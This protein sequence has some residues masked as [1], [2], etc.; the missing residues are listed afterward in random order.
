MPPSFWMSSVASSCTTSTMSSAVTM[1]RM[2]PSASTTGTAP[3]SSS[4]RIF[5]TASWS[6]SSG[7][8]TTSRPHDVRDLA[9]GRRGEELAQRHHAEQ[10]LIVVEDVD[11]VERLEVLARLTSQVADR[12][13]G[14]HVRTQP[15]EARAHQAAGV[16]LGVGEQRGDLGPAGGIEQREQPPALLGRHLFLLQHVGGVVGGEQAQP[17]PALGIAES[18]DD[19]GLRARGELVEELLGRGA[20]EQPEPLGALVGV[21]DRPHF[22]QRFGVD[23]LGGRGLGH[24]EDSGSLGVAVTVGPARRIGASSLRL[25]DGMIDA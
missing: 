16:V 22:A 5:A 12:L 1:P 20:I 6:M 4:A 7:T 13:V 25:G 21:E 8:L 18:Q 2:R 23:A 3:R 24:D 10:T 11:V 9:A 14:G 15:R 17:E 19:V